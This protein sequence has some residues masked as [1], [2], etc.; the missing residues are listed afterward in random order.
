MA[1]EVCKS[2]PYYILPFP[3]S[4]NTVGARVRECS[5]VR[6]RRSCISASKSGR[7]YIIYVRSWHALCRSGGAM[8]GGRWDMGDSGFPL[9]IDSFISSLLATLVRLS[10]TSMNQSESGFASHPSYCTVISIQRTS[11]S[12]TCSGLFDAISHAFSLICPRRRHSS[13]YYIQEEQYHHVCNKWTAASEFDI[14]GG[15]V[16]CIYR[17]TK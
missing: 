10:K 13:I 12:K 11:C 8:G 4:Y 6:S 1:R 15:K 2:L 17:I 14:D 7:V 3:R 16:L 9:F 5:S